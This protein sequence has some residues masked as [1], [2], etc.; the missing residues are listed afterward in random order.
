MSS[1]LLATGRQ[2]VLYKCSELRQAFM[3]RFEEVKKLKKRDFKTA[4]LMHN[5]KQ[6]AVS[7][8]ACPARA[9][10]R[11]EPACLRTFRNPAGGQS[12]VLALIGLHRNT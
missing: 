6:D 3:W 7:V 8:G 2:S 11:R 1:K 4:L 12:G 10:H 5:T 9:Q